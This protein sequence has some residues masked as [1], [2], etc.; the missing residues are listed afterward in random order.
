MRR[1]DVCACSWHRSRGFWRSGVGGC[2]PS[3]DLRGAYLP[4]SVQSGPALT[5][6]ADSYEGDA[7]LAAEWALASVARE[8]QGFVLGAIFATILVPVWG[9][10]DWL[11][12]PALLRPFLSLRAINATAVS[13][14]SG[15]LTSKSSGL[16]RCG[17]CGQLPHV[18]LGNARP[19][20]RVE[21]LPR[22]MELRHPS[23][24]LNG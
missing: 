19:K 15:C 17:E 14:P 9:V 11:L 8:R 3:H 2:A 7:L 21:R 16:L 20:H 12:E 6:V 18:R 10:F 1:G 24:P 23:T 4:D 22:R 5:P 13:T